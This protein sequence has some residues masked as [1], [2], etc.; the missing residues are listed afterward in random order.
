MQFLKKFDLSFVNILKVAGLALVAILLIALAFRLIG[1]FFY[2]LNGSVPQSAPLAGSDKVFYETEEAD[3]SSGSATDLSTRNITSSSAVAGDDAEE[4]EVTEYNAVIETRHLAETCGKVV[5]LKNREDVI[6]ENANEAEN[7]CDY[8]FKVKKDSVPEIL[9]II[10]ALDPKE[11]NE[12]TYT[13]KRLIDDYT[14]ELEILQK[15]MASIDQTLADAVKA[16]DEI[17]EVASRT[18]NAESLAKIIDSKINII[19]RLTTQR[20]NVNSQIERLERS[21][22]EQL[23]RLE[24]TYFYVSVF[25]NKFVDGQ[26]LKDSWKAAVKLFVYDINEIAQDITINL[27]SLLFLAL[28]YV[29]YAFILLIAAK[30]LWQLAKYIWSRK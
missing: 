3:Y 4:F 21:K 14:S 26:N 29:L 17:A 23:D 7:G 5:S 19:E 18:Q 11:I 27:V 22:A 1:T 15:K 30:Y 12:N 24:Y 25:E 9:G 20:L 10:K 28:Q 8:S 6:F 16:Y 2:S 13:I